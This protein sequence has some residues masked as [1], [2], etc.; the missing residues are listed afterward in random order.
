MA[1]SGNL[2]VRHCNDHQNVRTA[3]RK[4]HPELSLQVV[5]TPNYPRNPWNV[6]T[7]QKDRGMKRLR[8]PCPSPTKTG[9]RFTHSSILPALWH[10]KPRWMWE[11]SLL[12]ALL[13]SPRRPLAHGLKPGSISTFLNGAA[14][15]GVVSTSLPN[16]PWAAWEVTGRSL[17][18]IPGPREAARAG[19]AQATPSLT[20]LPKCWSRFCRLGSPFLSRLLF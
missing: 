19:L 18:T 12:T 8:V 9:S 16:C 3:F 13:A 1:Y 10:C 17:L 11:P 7:S 20:H 15:P 14:V 5:S 6:P 4:G 2:S